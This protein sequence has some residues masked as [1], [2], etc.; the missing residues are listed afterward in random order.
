MPALAHLDGRAEVSEFSRPLTRQWAPVSP[1]QGAPVDHAHASKRIRSPRPESAHRTSNRSQPLCPRRARGPAANALI[2]SGDRDSTGRTEH[3]RAVRYPRGV[4]RPRPIRYRRLPGAGRA[5]HGSVC[6]LS[7][8]RGAAVDDL[9]E[10]A[11]GYRTATPN[12]GVA[13]E[14]KD[15]ERRALAQPRAQS[16]GARTDPRTSDPCT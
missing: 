10:E 1:V 11:G 3:S 8:A 9:S 15:P 14:P 2:G 4:S 7:R 13:L 16:F 12:D 5:V 6:L